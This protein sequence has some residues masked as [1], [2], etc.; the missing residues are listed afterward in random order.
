MNSTV[1]E[2]VDSYAD[3][4]GWNWTRRGRLIYEKDGYE[5]YFFSQNDGFELTVRNPETREREAVLEIRDNEVDTSSPLYI[6]ILEHV[7]KNAETIV[8]NT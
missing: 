6:A 3:A 8:A 5:V 1:R 4:S 7:L 2:R